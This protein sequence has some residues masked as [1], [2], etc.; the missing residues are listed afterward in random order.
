MQNG[1]GEGGGGVQT[2]TE[3]IDG[4][5][6]VVPVA[7][8]QTPQ[9]APAPRTGQ[10]SPPA[11]TAPA[12]TPAPATASPAPAANATTPG[13]PAPEMQTETGTPSAP[14]TAAATMDDGVSMIAV[15]LCAGVI[16]YALLRLVFRNPNG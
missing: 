8:P 3:V 14:P 7:A 2:T 11:A 12:H 1:S 16:A 15:I 6:F 9:D 10:S 4:Q 13:A 5:T